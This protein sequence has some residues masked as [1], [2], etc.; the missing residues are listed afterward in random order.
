MPNIGSSA[1]F[2]VLSI[3]PMIRSFMNDAPGN[4]FTDSVLLPYI[5]SSYRRVQRKLA[6]AGSSLF[7]TDN[8][9]LVIAAVP[10]A[11]QGIGTQV[12]LNDASEP[13][14]QLPSN[15]LQPLKISERPNL[16]TQHFIEMQ[17]R[18]MHD[19][20]PLRKQGQTL[21]DWEW[22]TDGIYFVGATQ[23]TEID[24][25]YTVSLPDLAGPTD[26]VMIRFSQEAI[27]YGAAALAGG[28]RGSPLAQTYADEQDQADEDLIAYFVRMAQHSGGRR[29]K[30]FSSRGGPRGGRSAANGGDWI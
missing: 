26:Y 1:Y 19:G 4:V 5:Q 17:D 14:N 28:A 2:Q 3:T 18:T 29:R 30:P 6:I 15:L 7:I 22:R 11:Q 13:P 16:S 21:R 25:R 27:A 20:L 12:V 23:D 24:L 9:Q 10:S 8:I